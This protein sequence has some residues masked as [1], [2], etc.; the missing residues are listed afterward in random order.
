MTNCQNCDG[1]NSTRCT[2][3]NATAQFLKSDFTGCWDD[4]KKDI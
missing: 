4:C 3:C 1:G 2:K